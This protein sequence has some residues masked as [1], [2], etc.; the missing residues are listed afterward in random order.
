MKSLDIVSITNTLLVLQKMELVLVVVFV[1]LR[2]VMKYSMR[3][4]TPNLR[5]VGI[6][7]TNFT[8]KLSGNGHLC[9]SR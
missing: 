7:N 3:R 2:I 4:E 8:T 6:H 5:I 1:P 9:W